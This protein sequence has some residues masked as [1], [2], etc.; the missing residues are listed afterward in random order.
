MQSVSNQSFCELFVFDLGKDFSHNAF[1]TEHIVSENWLI[2][3]LS[4]ILLFVLTSFT[5]LLNVG[6]FL[7]NPRLNIS[8]LSQFHLVVTRITI[9]NRVTENGKI[10]RCMVTVR[11]KIANTIFV[12]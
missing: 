1:A 10:Q 3:S 4:V 7:I 11:V 6:S 2:M 12:D 5:I 8:F 9:N